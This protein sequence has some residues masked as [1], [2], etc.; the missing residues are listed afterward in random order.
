MCDTE[1]VLRKQ[2]GP[3]AFPLTSASLCLVFKADSCNVALS[4]QPWAIAG[5]TRALF[6]PVSQVPGTGPGTAL[7]SANSNGK[8]TTKKGAKGEGGG[9]EEEGRRKGQER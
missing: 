7:G 4:C 5:E 9:G 3:Q 1:R 2:A 6:S 8:K